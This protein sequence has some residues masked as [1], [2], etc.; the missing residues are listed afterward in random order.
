MRRS[1]ARAALVVAAA[2]LILCAT[3]GC[4]GENDDGTGS[5]D[6]ARVSWGEP[7]GGNPRAVVMLIHGGGWQPSDSGYEKQKA[8]AGVLQSQGYATVAIG[9]DEGARGFRQ[10]VDVYRAA[11]ERYPNLPV[12]ATGIS[13]GG[14]LSLML[15]TREPELDCVVAVSAPTDLIT[16]AKQDAQGDEVYQAA[17]EAFGP[18]QLAMFSPVRYADKIQAKVL[19]V[20]AETDPLVPAEQGRELARSLPGAQLLVL[21]PGPVRAEWAHWGGV[22][23]NAQ[24]VVLKREFEFLESATQGH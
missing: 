23:P 12:C 11:R 14:N 15:A 21:P 4:G 3:A 7:S 9:Y 17:I 2:L 20:N 24:N 18:D 16:L 6:G 8:N 19:L 1:K 13:A 10:V 22:Q 5:V